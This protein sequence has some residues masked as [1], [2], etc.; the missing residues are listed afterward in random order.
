MLEKTEHEGA[1]HDVSERDTSVPSWPSRG[2][3]V[4]VGARHEIDRIQP[5]RVSVPRDGL[6]AVVHV[7]GSQRVERTGQVGKLDRC[8]EGAGE[9]ALQASPVAAARRLLVLHVEDLPLDG[10]DNEGP[11]I[12]GRPQQSDVVGEG[13]RH[14][15]QDSTFRRG[16][17]RVTGERV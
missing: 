14:A 11:A 16:R 12:E 10:F 4:V 3:P 7:R 6:E 1:V 13:G 5:M 15:W 9:Q 2:I 17:S 8:V